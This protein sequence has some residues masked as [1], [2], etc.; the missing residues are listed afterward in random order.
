M[1]VP[2]ASFLSQEYFCPGSLRLVVKLPC[3]GIL[4]GLLIRYLASMLMGFIGSQ[5]RTTES[6]NQQPKAA[7]HH[8]AGRWG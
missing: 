3:T 2:K 4:L 1:A 7:S 8:A 5:R 6:R